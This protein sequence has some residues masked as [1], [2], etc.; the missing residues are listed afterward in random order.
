[1]LFCRFV[2]CCCFVLLEDQLSITWVVVVVCRRRRRRLRG[3][4]LLSRVLLVRLQ[5]EPRGSTGVETTVH[6]VNSACK[7][8][9]S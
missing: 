2:D 7:M 5:D 9:T 3:R 8:Q 6:T 1:M 4:G